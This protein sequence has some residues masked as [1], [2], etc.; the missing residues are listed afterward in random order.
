MT[1]LDKLVYAYWHTR[2]TWDEFKE[3]AARLSVV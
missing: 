1:A 3:R 2:M